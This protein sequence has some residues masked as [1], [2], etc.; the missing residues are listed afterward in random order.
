MNQQLNKEKKPFVTVTSE[1]VHVIWTYEDGTEY[2]STYPPTVEGA[3]EAYDELVG[4]QYDYFLCSSSV[5][6]V[7]ECGVDTRAGQILRGQ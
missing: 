5:D 7:E 3:K 6:F 1:G 4:S 2:T